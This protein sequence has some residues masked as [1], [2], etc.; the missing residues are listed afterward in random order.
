MSE[1]YC[2][3]C[4]VTLSSIYNLR[5]HM[6]TNLHKKRLNNRPISNEYK[7][8]CGKVYKH[9]Q[10][11]YHHRKSCEV[12]INS[13]GEQAITEPT[14]VEELRSIVSELLE[15]NAE[16]EEKLS[17][18]DKVANSITNTNSHNNTTNTN[19]HNNNTTNNN[20]IININP[21]GNE[22]LDHI[23]KKKIITCLKEVYKS[24]PSLVEQIH[25]DPK[26]PE[27]HNVKITNKKLPYASVMGED[28]K[29][30]MMK[31]K[32]VIEKMVDNSYTH[33]DDKYQDE[34]I[35][36]KLSESKQDR[37]DEF[38][39]KY[40]AYDKNTIKNIHDDVE[41]LVLNNSDRR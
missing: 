7:C 24:I 21:F 19:S 32:D 38:K 22:N 10:N 26:H 4:D 14:E 16:L 6:N 33:L 20:T 34:E 5:K 23:T 39:E 2:E 37:I 3:V 36:N 18:N 27:N 11:R 40:D 12:Y 8:I 25:F 41:L 29:W 30:K 9:R 17:D 35:R 1:T 15:R 31:R 28:K 13:R